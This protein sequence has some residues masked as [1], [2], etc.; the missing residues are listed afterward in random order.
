[1]VQEKL[2]E[3]IVGCFFLGKQKLILFLKYKKNS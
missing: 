3:S 1:L 2:R